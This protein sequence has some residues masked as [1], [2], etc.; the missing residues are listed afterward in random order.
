[1]FP[2][3]IFL[4]RD[5]VINENRTDHVKSWDEFIFLPGALNAI[6]RLSEA[7]IRLFVITNQ[8]VINRGIVTRAQVDAVNNRMVEVIHQFGGRIEAVVYCPHRPEERCPCRKP[9]PGLLFQLSEQYQVNLSATLLIGDAWPD[10]DAGRAAGCNV[11]LVLTGRGREQLAMAS[12]E[13]EN[14]PIAKD[15]FEA[16]LLVLDLANGRR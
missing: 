2:T 10:I 16:S 7:G 8:A 12:P 11:M 14:V 6:A 13:Y 4:D 1:M 15:L 3:T 5:G 9:A